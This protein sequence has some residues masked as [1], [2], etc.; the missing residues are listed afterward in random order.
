MIQMNLCMKQKQTHRLVKHTYGYQRDRLG[1]GL[2]KDLRIN[3][4]TL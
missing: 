4:Y 3:I 1:E 2:N